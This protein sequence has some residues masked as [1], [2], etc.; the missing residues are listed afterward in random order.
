MEVL[1]WL[2]EPIRIWLEGGAWADIKATRGFQLLVLG[3]AAIVPSTLILIGIGGF[4][5]WRHTPLAMWLGFNPRDPD[6]DWSERAR[7]IDKDGAPDF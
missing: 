5:E 3:A 6:E 7:D 2:A 4:S 1:A